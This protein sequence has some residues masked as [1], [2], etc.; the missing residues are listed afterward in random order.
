[1]PA[2]HALVAGA[3]GIVGRRIAEHLS[4]VGWR[5]TGLCRNPPD[6]T[7]PYALMPLDLTDATACL[8]AAQNLPDV[9]HVFYAARYD[10]PEGVTESIDI[11]AAM[12]RNLVQSLAPAARGLRHV[13]LVFGSKYYGHMA[14]PVP[15]PLT[16]DVPRGRGSTYYFEQEDFIRAAQRGTS[17]TYSSSRPHAFIDPSADEPRNLALLIAIY[18]SIAR[19]CGEPLAY[20]GTERSFSARTQFTFVPM[21]A[22]A[23]A[24]MA[25]EPRCANQAYHVVNGDSPRWCDL[26]P[27]FARYF[28]LSSGAPN[29]PRLADCM[30]KKIDIW[31]ELVERH[32]LRASRLESIVLWPYADYVF[33]PEWDIISS[34]SK[35]R[36]DGFTESVD[37]VQMFTDLFDRFRREKII[38]AEA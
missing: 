27:E 3:T 12:L 9:T 13:H 34:M 17:W 23:A 5:V 16:E 33:R 35:A 31:S 1:M 10:H 26:W 37:S 4:E 7:L 24:W 32:G 22:R 38:P 28:G 30:A 8:N 20:P 14:G 25:E 21:L 36:R 29:G 2:K 6:A 15:V 19:E 18:A 11:N